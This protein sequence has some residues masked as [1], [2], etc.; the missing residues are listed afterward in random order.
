MDQNL[1][2]ITKKVRKMFNPTRDSEIEEIRRRKIEE[3]LKRVIQPLNN[4][5]IELSDYNFSTEINKNKI[6]VVDFWAPWCG[7]CKMISPVIEQ[8][9]SEYAGKVVFAKL[10]VDNNQR[11]A[12]RYNVQGIPTL[13]LFKDGQLIDRLV[14]A[15]PKSYI[16]SKIKSHI[17]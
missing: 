12:Q 14:G 17:Y 11:T 10:N 7:P 16:E 13:L 4:K 1:Q 9:A 3:M 15:A 5:T 6:V 8:L 2:T